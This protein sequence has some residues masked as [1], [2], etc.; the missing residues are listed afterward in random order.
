MQNPQYKSMKPTPIT[1]TIRRAEE[2]LEKLFD[3]MPL[4]SPENYPKI[5]SHI[6]STHLALLKAMEEEVGKKSFTTYLGAM[7]SEPKVLLRDVL[8]LLNQAQEELLTTPKQ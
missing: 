5:L 2:T 6:K 4:Y 3:S 8:S 1:D 7:E